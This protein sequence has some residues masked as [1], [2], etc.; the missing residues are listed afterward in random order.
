MI[1]RIDINLKALLRR[2]VSYEAMVKYSSPWWLW[3]TDY[4]HSE[5][6]SDGLRKLL[7]YYQT[8]DGVGR[9]PSSST[10]HRPILPKS[11]NTFV[12]ELNPLVRRDSLSLKGPTSCEWKQI[13]STMAIKRTSFFSNNNITTHCLG[14]LACR[15]RLWVNARYAKAIIYHYPVFFRPMCRL[16]VKRA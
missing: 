13:L 1:I 16:I 6:I 9:T 10:N 12:T 11:N 2:A 8:I 15:N 5:T 3:K 4:D 14:R 7:K